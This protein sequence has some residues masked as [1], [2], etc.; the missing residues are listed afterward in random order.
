MRALRNSLDRGV[1]APGALAVG[2][3]ASIGIAMAP[4]GV[5]RVICAPW[6]IQVA[7]DACTGRRGAIPRRRGAIPRRR[8]AIACRRHRQARQCDRQACQCDRQA[9]QCDRHGMPSV[10]ALPAAV[11]SVMAPP[12]D[13]W[14]QRRAR[15]ARPP[16]GRA[17]C[18]APA[19]RARTG[20]PFTP[21]DARALASASTCPSTA[22]G[23]RAQAPPCPRSP[24]RCRPAFAATTCPLQVPINALQAP[25]RQAPARLLPGSCQAPRRTCPARARRGWRPRRGGSRRRRR[26]RR[27]R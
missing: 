14:A 26:S 9:R 10:P 8:G 5:R 18:A 20:A 15:Q 25:A 6:E 21:H 11:P 22:E 17:S 1:V 12:I 23:W 4:A 3:E 13:A 2:V 19:F 27:C 24:P 7:Q 16:L